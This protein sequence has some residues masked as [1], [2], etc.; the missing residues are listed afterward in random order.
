MDARATYNRL[1][2][3]NEMPEKEFLNR[4]SGII[5]ELSEL[6]SITLIEGGKQNTKSPIESG[7]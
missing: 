2:Y 7:S 6:L 1:S 3:T 5:S 4:L